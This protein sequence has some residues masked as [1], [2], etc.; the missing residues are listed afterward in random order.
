M[1]ELHLHVVADLV[2][3]RA[4]DEYGE[5]EVL[6]AEGVVPS[7]CPLRHCRAYLCLVVLVD[8]TV[9]VDVDKLHV[10]NVCCGLGVIVA[11]VCAP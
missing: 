1:C 4:V 9:T 5:V 3:Y 8:D 11:R 6:V 10:A 7:E 2:S